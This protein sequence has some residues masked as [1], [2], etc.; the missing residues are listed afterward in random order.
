M[1]L[2]QKSLTST[3][4]PLVSPA[5]HT[6][7]QALDVGGANT[8]ESRVAGKD[9]FS[10]ILIVRTVDDPP[11]PMVQ[12]EGAEARTHNDCAKK[13]KGVQWRALLVLEVSIHLSLVHTLLSQNA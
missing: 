8:V 5:P 9:Y 13:R 6:V 4:R 10:S 11:F 3:T 7:G 12:R 2:R 1:L